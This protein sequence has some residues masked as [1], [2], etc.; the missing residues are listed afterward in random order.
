M[1]QGSLRTEE[2][3]SLFK[4]LEALIEM[5]IAK[6]DLFGFDVL[7]LFTASGCFVLIIHADSYS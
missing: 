5:K 6:E 4:I 2:R 1:G 7:L 3:Y